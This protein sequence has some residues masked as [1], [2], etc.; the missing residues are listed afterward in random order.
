MDNKG[1][2]NRI[3]LCDYGDNGKYAY[4]IL[5]EK[6]PAKGKFSF[7]DEIATKIQKLF[8]KCLFG[9]PYVKNKNLD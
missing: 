9:V 3:Y 5:A 4:A 6:D 2:G 1:T 8:L 7:N